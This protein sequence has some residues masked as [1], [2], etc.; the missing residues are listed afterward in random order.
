MKYRFDRRKGNIKKD[1]RGNIKI[2]RVRVW[3]VCELIL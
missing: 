1:I 2:M 3:Y